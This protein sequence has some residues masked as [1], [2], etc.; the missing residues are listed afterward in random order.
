[1]ADSGQQPTAVSEVHTLV[2]DIFDIMSDMK[3]RKIDIG[4]ERQYFTIPLH[5]VPSLPPEVSAERLRKFMSLL[6]KTVQDDS[7]AAVPDKPYPSAPTAAIGHTH[8][9]VEGE[10]EGGQPGGVYR[11]TRA[12]ALLKACLYCA[13]GYKG[14]MGCYPRFWTS[15]H[16]GATCSRGGK[17]G[18]NLHITV[19]ARRM[20]IPLGE[21]AKKME[22][23]FRM[24][25]LDFA[26][27]KR[28]AVADDV[29]MCP[30]G[31]RR[32][33]YDTLEAYIAWAWPRRAHKV[34]ARA[35]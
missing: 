9:E 27:L 22:G 19:S 25:Y 16:P 7:N 31:A 10:V 18:V 6:Q 12:D 34:R 4:S 29:S 15:L 1:M 2:N 28:A 13:K 26:S 5:E 21:Q 17:H 23:V 11:G 30:I 14:K 20:L 33:T 35:D 8:G 24:K 3:I 32:V